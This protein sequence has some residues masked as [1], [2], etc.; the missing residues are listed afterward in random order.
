MLILVEQSQA[1]M[2]SNYCTVLGFMPQYSA[3][4]EVSSKGYSP[5]HCPVQYCSVHSRS[6]HLYLR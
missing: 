6:F 5:V 3:V 2:A 4:L 1:R